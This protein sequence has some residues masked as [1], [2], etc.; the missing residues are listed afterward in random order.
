M[1]IHTGEKP[2]KCTHEG[3][4]AACTT[5]GALTTHMRTHTGEKPYKCTHEGCDAA[6]AQRGARVTH[7][8]TH[9]GEKPFRCTHEGCDAALAQSGDLAKH[10]RTHTG[11]KPFRCT[12]EGCDAAFAQ[13][14]ALTTHMRTHTG[15]KPFRCAHEGCD[16]AFA[17]PG[18]LT[19][20]IRTHTG[21]KP[22]ECTHKGCDAAFAQSSQLKDHNHYYHTTEGQAERK[23]KEQRVAKVLTA[24]GIAFKREHQIDFSCL[25]G[26]FARIDFVIE[27]HGCILLVE[28]DEHQHEDGGY[29]CDARRMG[30]AVEA[31]ALGGNALPLIFVRYNPDAY[32]LRGVRVKQPLRAREAELLR[33]VR[34]YLALAPAAAP[35]PPLSIQYMYYDSDDGA[36]L[37]VW[38]AADYDQLLV[39][40]CLPA[41]M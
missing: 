24:A 13:S 36:T 7:M 15:E 32:S 12:H 17:Q 38:Q 25:G 23:H 34:R 33:V 16:A 11:E 26:T 19:T 5:S 41:V 21:E 27:G 40:C 29:S 31:L 4:D 9:T 22:F 1:R 2:Y 6:F 39:P 37:D 35:L 3:C 20:H 10:I 30:R 18:H 8:R 28:V 14:G